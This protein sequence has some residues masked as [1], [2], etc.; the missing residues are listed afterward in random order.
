MV[1][2]Y[3]EQLINMMKGDEEDGRVSIGLSGRSSK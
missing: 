2:L 1:V 3:S